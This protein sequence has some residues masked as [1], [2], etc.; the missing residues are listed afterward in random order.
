VSALIEDASHIDEIANTLHTTT[1][2]DD[3]GNLS[4]PGLR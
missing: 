3:T 2:T 4:N 1:R